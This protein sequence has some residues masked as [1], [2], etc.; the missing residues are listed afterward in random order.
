M[1]SLL[2]PS[3]G[4]IAQSK[5]LFTVSVFTFAILHMGPFIHMLPLLYPEAVNRNVSSVH[6]SFSILVDFLI[7]CLAHEPTLRMIRFPIYYNPL[8]I[9][10]RQS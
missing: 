2:V 1:S 5:V 4:S 10:Q 8:L 7:S 9:L 6:H 3:L